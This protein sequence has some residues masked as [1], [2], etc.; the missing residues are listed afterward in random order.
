MGLKKQQFQKRYLCWRCRTMIWSVQ[1]SVWCMSL[2]FKLDLYFVATL[3]K[4]H[5]PMSRFYG[6]A[7][8]FCKL[9]SKTHVFEVW[10]PIQWSW[11]WVFSHYVDGLRPLP[12]ANWVFWKQDCYKSSQ[13]SCSASLFLFH[14]CPLS[15]AA[16]WYGGLR[17]FLKYLSP[18]PLTS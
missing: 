9:V 18:C 11:V 2:L 5:F 12:L 7:A 13:S 6:Q 14:F 15:H 4:S 16:L 1:I 3:W 10:L 8:M 17:A